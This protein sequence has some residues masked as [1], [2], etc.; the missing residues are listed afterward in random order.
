[1]RVWRTLIRVSSSPLP[2][3]SSL[4]AGTTSVQFV[5]VDS[6]LRTVPGSETS[7][8]DVCEGTCDAMGVA[9]GTTARGVSTR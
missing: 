9:E 4:R 5:V 2:P 8:V 3:T 7:S 6:M 1:M